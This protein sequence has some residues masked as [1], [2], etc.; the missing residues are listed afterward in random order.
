MAITNYSTLTTAINDWADRSY[1]S[2]KLQEFVALAESEF[3]LVPQFKTYR[4]ETTDATLTTDANGEATLPT[5]FIRMRSIVRDYSGATPLK[6]VG[7]AQ[8][9][10]LNPD[11]QTGIPIW[12]A[13]SGTTLKVADVVADDFITTY[14]TALT[15]LT[16]GNETNWLITL[17][18]LSYLFMCLAMVEGYNKNFDEAAVWKAQAMQKL[19]EIGI[20]SDLAQYGNAGIELE[21]VI[22]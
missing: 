17:S 7:W 2:D 9:R 15:A 8:L 14:E 18:P 21:Q 10:E 11:S 19:A 22:P 5:G 6:P 4:R 3:N 1:T 20:Q 16:S 12:Y 13:I